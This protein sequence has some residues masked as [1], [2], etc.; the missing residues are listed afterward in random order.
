[1]AKKVVTEEQKKK[2]AEQ[3]I[4][5]CTAKGY[6][7][8]ADGVPNPIFTGCVNTETL[9]GI[10]EAEKGNLEKWYSKSKEFIKEE[11]GLTGFLTKTGDIITN[12]KNWRNSSTAPSDWEANVQPQ[13]QE[14]LDKQKRKNII[15]GVVVSI[16]FISLIV[17]YIIY[18]RKQ[19]R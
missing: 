10:K 6:L 14:E 1:M 8:V 19:N 7:P 3:A 5:I 12:L 4:M 2:I 18:M 9:N 11:G 17:A 13:T 16:V 15:I